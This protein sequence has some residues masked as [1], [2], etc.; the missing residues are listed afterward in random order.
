MISAKSALGIV[1]F[2]AAC[3]SGGLRTGGPFPRE[4]APAEGLRYHVARNVIALDTRVIAR[5]GNEWSPKDCSVVPVAGWNRTE[6]ELSTP[7]VGD[8]R[9]TFRLALLPSRSVDQTFKVT[10]NDNGLLSSLNYTAQD[11]TAEIAGNILRG[12]A[13][14]A[15][16]ALGITNFGF[17]PLGAARAD[18][19]PRQLHVALPEYCYLTEGGSQAEALG[20]EILGLEAELR[21]ARSEHQDLLARASQMPA[22][23]DVQRLRAQDTLLTRSEAILGDRI[24]ERRATLTVEANE[25]ARLKLVTIKADTVRYFDSFDLTELPTDVRRVSLESAIQ[26]MPATVPERARA[27]FRSTQLVLSVTDIATPGIPQQ[28]ADRQTDTGTLACERRDPEKCARIY[29]RQPAMRVLRIYAPSSAA[30]TAPLALLETRSIP[31]V[32]SRDPVLNVAVNAAAIGNGSATI[33]FGPYSN[34]TSLEQ[35]ANAQLA[36]ATS[37]L[38]DALTGARQEFVGGLQAAQTAQSTVFAM[39]TNARAARIKEL[40]DQKALIDAQV[41][42]Q[43]ANANRSLLEQKAAVDAQLALL[44]AQQA[45]EASQHTASTSTELQQMRDEITRVQT[46]LQLLQQ[47][48]ALEKAQRDLEAA[49]NQH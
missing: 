31:L 45:L 44:N 9:Q 15:G 37:T 32:S 33:A 27:F 35:S 14:I 18:Q 6:Y 23:G 19:S 2:T 28:V 22:V 34:V 17:T 1:C 3:S 7:V 5:S 49:R 47:Q 8:E 46:Q 4:Q 38:A 12:V 39:Q 40:S 41:A 11:R 16:T 43:G 42:L 29:Y 24:I 20:K 13:G 26:A 48:L 36:K 25:F 30:S 10:V 21:Q